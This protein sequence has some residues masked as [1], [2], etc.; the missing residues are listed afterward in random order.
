MITAAAKD[1][2]AVDVSVYGQNTVLNILSNE[3]LEKEFE[4]VR[5]N[6]AYLEE[7]ERRRQNVMR[8]N[9]VR[10]TLEELREMAGG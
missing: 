5:R 10:V 3:E 6:A 9:V 2:H 8:G 4:R 7:M 1:F